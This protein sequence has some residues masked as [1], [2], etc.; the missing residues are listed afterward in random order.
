MQPT[1]IE[2]SDPGDRLL[3]EELFGPIVTAYVY[4]DSKWDETLELVDSTSPYG[5]TGAVFARDRAAIDDAAEK[6][7]YAA[8][9]FYVNDKP[10]G[11]V[12]G[13]QPFGGA[14]RL[15]HERQ[16]RLDVEPDPL[17]QPAHDQG[18]VRAPHGLPLSVP[19][20]GRHCRAPRRQRLTNPYAGLT[21]RS[22]RA[23]TFGDMRF[24]VVAFGWL[25]LIVLV[26]PSHV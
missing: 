22:D 15:G 19:G 20:A 5:L 1:V 24:L 4:P 18:D 10:T 13:Q 8:G 7:Q 3:R 23:D 2:T 21:R 9:N 17:G 12:V 26:V 14:T 6:L 25:T 11:A 16:G